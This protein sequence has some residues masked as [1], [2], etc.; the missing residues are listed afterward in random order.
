M[1]DKCSTRI[2]RVP[3]Q[4]GTSTVKFYYE[5]EQSCKE[6]SPEL[7][8]CTE[9]VLRR[10]FSGIYHHE[11]ELRFPTCTLCGF[12]KFKVNYS[13]QIF[14]LGFFFPFRG[15]E[16]TV[17]RRI[18]C[19]HSS[20]A[21]GKGQQQVK[22]ISNVNSLSLFHCSQAWVNMS[23]LKCVHTHILLLM[24]CRT[25]GELKYCDRE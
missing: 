18:Q 7:F 9:N 25:P 8:F 10:Y 16:M 17:V 15:K 3:S 1:K 24:E 5:L 22:Q 23:K 21:A 20:C 12:N 11:E 14:F 6:Q 2:Q 19:R 13:N 4:T